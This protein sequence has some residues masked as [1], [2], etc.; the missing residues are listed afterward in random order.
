MQ[1]ELMNKDELLNDMISV[2]LRKMKKD[3]VKQKYG[4]GDKK[5]KKLKYE[6]VT[7][8]GIDP[9]VLFQEFEIK[10]NE[11]LQ[12]YCDDSKIDKTINEIKKEV[13]CLDEERKKY[14]YVTRTSTYYDAD[15][16]TKGEWVRREID[17]EAMLEG[18]IQSI[19]TL[20]SEIQPSANISIDKDYKINEDIMV[21]L[22]IVDL[23]LGLKID[24][25]NVSHG[26][27]WNLEIAEAYYTNAMNHLLSTAPAA[28]QLVLFDGGDIMHAHDNTN[29]T[30]KSGHDLDTSE[31]YEKVML[32]L[33]EM[34]KATVSAALTK[35]EEV[36]FYSVPGN[37]NDF[38]SLTLKAILIE[39]FKD[40][41]RF[42]CSLDKYTNVYYHKFG[43]SIIGMSHGDEIKPSK[44]KDVMIADNF[45]I[46]SNYKY[47]DFYF[48]H[49]H[50]NKF[51]EDG[52]VNV[53]CLKP[54]IPN[55][56][57]ADG[58]GFRNNDVGF[59]QCFVYS[60]TSGMISNITYRKP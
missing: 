19:K 48:G 55:D 3:D 31:K 23:H 7:D 53:K 57:W 40:N 60:E 46:I 45:N 20:A 10:N 27:P 54:L 50:Q 8:Y 43:N 49:F 15:G 2:N 9:R 14:M 25:Q 34:M 17:N 39:T 51:V 56:R 44:A 12:K 30:K 1:T 35:F 29:K 4:I 41:P 47:L 36:Y 11:E 21:F 28:K 38:I 16:N 33:I 18:V 58:V 37:H 32:R 42:K 24:P 13:K 5:Y 22:P 6:F 59:A 52:V 26:I